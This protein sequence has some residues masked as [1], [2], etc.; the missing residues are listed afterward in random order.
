[1]PGKGTL[2]QCGRCFPTRIH[3][4]GEDAGQRTSSVLKVQQ[5]FNATVASSP[6][7]LS[8]MYTNHLSKIT[9]MSRVSGVPP[10]PEAL[11]GDGRM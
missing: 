3:E 8:K 2:N 1:M 6:I 9:P 5:R 7:D 4:Q 11:L 10:T